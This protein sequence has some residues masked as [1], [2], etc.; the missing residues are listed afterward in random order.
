MSA[1]SF[2]WINIALREIPF[3][4]ILSEASFFPSSLVEREKE[5]FDLSGYVTKD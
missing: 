4:N 2:Q 5:Y 3:L 1:V